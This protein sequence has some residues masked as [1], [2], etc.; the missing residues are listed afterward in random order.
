[1]K[2][3]LFLGIFLSIITIFITYIH[4]DRLAV[5]YLFI[6]IYTLI[7]FIIPFLIGKVI[8]RAPFIS[9][10]SVT[11]FLLYPC[12]LLIIKSAQIL[13]NLNISYL[14]SAVACILFIL[15]FLL[16]L[17]Y[18][19]VEP[20][21]S[22]YRTLKSFVLPIIVIV[23]YLLFN[24][25]L[26]DFGDSISTD[27]YIHK[28]AINGI[29]SSYEI[30]FFP[31][32]Y[33]SAFTDRAYFIGIFHSMLYFLSFGFGLDFVKVAYIIDIVFSLVVVV[34]IYNV[35]K[36]L[37]SSDTLR[38][39]VLLVSVFAF[40]NLAYTTQ[41]FLPQ[42]LAFLLF[43]IILAALNTTR[44]SL[45]KISCVFTIL[46]TSHFVI[47][48]FLTLIIVLSF[49][50]RYF[51]IGIQALLLWALVLSL[52]LATTGF[53]LG[54]ILQSGYLNYFG[55][56]SDSFNIIFK[57]ESLWII[58]GPIWLLIIVSLVFFT[59]KKKPANIVLEAS[60]IGVVINIIVFILDP[61][62]AGKF[63][64]GIGIF[65]S[66]LIA[67]FLDRYLVSKFYFW[68]ILTF[69][70]AV[71]IVSYLVNFGSLMPFLKQQGGSSNV[72]G[73]EDVPLANY[74]REQQPY[75]TAVSDPQTQLVIHSL[76]EGLSA[77]ALYLSLPSREVVLEFIQNPNRKNLSNIFSIEE[78]MGRTDVC[79]VLSSK[80]QYLRR[81]DH[82]WL[83]TVLN[84]LAINPGKL[85]KNDS[86][87]EFFENESQLA[88]KLYEDEYYEV[89]KL[90]YQ[91]FK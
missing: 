17:A 57:I 30:G 5:Q 41:F 79:F 19:M 50:V 39:L 6:A 12:L 43:L 51:K 78:L 44:L 68:Q 67:W 63:L 91:V 37:L 62:F 7:V 20:S 18:I 66:M 2:Y 83:K 11:S 65:G 73:R 9:L 23:T 72:V 46:V 76:G 71:I 86:V 16:L 24:L 61:I 1:M 13:F 32:S 60:A 70:S 31:D 49:G 48:T 36:S 75:C 14:N 77:R 27:I 22:I 88:L 28:T 52:L 35:S 53:S 56:T 69:T 34:T 90:S 38:L 64:I 3:K 15:F 25:L 40:E 42:T 58:F 80:L 45:V 81:H 54:S 8:F 33:S 87:Q 85:S 10:A 47:G 89:Y 59:F 21:T 82:S 29:K 55:I 4:T 74:W 84:Y 26:K